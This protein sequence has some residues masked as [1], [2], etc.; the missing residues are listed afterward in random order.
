ME[1]VE[2][3]STRPWTMT[4]QVRND[5]RCPGC[6]ELLRDVV[7]TFAE[8]WAWCPVCLNEALHATPHLR[9]VL[10]HEVM[11]RASIVSHGMH[12]YIPQ[13]TD[14][15]YKNLIDMYEWLLSQPD[16]EVPEMMQWPGFPPDQLRANLRTAIADGKR[17]WR[18]A[19]H[20]PK[21]FYLA[22]LTADNRLVLMQEHPIMLEMSQS[23]RP[24]GSGPMHYPDSE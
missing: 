2:S 16:E 5:P 14:E 9:Y 13:R 22:G 8:G 17:P 21:G 18:A 6:C 7:I 12:F 4:F 20:V 10:E 1:H 23:L 24:E 19:V 15:G 3:E 11:T